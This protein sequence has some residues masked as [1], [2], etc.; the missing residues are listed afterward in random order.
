MP[1]D[2]DRRLPG[3]LPLRPLLLRMPGA[4]PAAAEGAAQ[5]LSVLPPQPPR[6]RPRPSA[7]VRTLRSLSAIPLRPP[8]RLPLPIGRRRPPRAPPVLGGD[9]HGV[10]ASRRALPGP[11]AAGQDFALRGPARCCAPTRPLLRQSRR[12][13]LLWLPALPRL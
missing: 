6:S 11:P 9:P 10:P 12:G 7:P 2:G 4:W 8:R 3:H 13:R 1:Q 5:R